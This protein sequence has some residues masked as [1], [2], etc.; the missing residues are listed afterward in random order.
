MT[1]PKP[2]RPSI[3][4]I[5]AGRLGQ[6]LAIALKASGYTIDALVAR[7][8]RKAEHVLGASQLEQLPA[9]QLV[10]IATPDD[11]IEAVAKRLAA[12][13]TTRKRGRV[14]LH[15]SGALSSEALRPLTDSRVH[16]GSFHPLVS[17]S[18]PHSGAKALRGA[19]YCV[20]GDR[21]A[22]RV[23][24]NI[25]ADL[26]GT[27]FTIRPESKGLYHAAAVM[28]SPHLVALFDL[29]IEMLTA[30]GLNRQTA[31]KVLVPLL[32]STV[33]NLR[34]SET[35]KA[36]TGTFA[37][38]DLATV[39]RH[40]KALSGKDEAEAREVYRLLGLHSLSLAKRN[41]VDRK[42]LERI[43]KLLESGRVK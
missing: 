1:K 34:V 7:R 11:A 38:G 12:V 32:Q 40:L 43:R 22:V 5:G 24:K 41:G 31:R 18:D 21:A 3:S 42:L 4:I 37:R 10:I 14:V 17:V 2:P 8:A 9:S 33:E 20:E 39:Q 23:A 35:D 25:V 6:A 15:T 27:S 30:C 16:T 19:F 13:K 29:A 36:L 28:A 26:K